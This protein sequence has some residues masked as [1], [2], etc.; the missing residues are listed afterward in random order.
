MID[1]RF[2]DMNR[3]IGELTNLVLALTDRYPLT[4]EKGMD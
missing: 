3:Q 1:Q 2:Y 4:L